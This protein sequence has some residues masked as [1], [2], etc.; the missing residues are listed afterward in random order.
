[1]ALN[2]ARKGLV[3]VNTSANDMS[4]AFGAAAAVLNSG[5]TLKANG[6]TWVMDAFNYTTEAISAIAGAAGSNLA[7]QEFV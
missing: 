7:V 4:L 5:I 6:G 3:L 1:M 2:A